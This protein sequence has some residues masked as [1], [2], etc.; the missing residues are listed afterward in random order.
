MKTTLCFNFD[1]YP[2]ETHKHETKRSCQLP[3]S[4]CFPKLLVRDQSYKPIPI[5]SIQKIDIVGNIN[6]ILGALT[7]F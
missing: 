3:V 6:V 2:K 7:L 4:L 5:E 1:F